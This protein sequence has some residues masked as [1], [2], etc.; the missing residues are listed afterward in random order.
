MAQLVTLHLGK[1]FRNFRG[2]VEDLRDGIL[3]EGGQ[4]VRREEESS[5]RSLWHDSGATLRSLQEEV[6]REGDAIT[7]RLFPTATSDKGAP[8]PLFGEYGTGRR[9][10]IT[11]RP[12]P[13]GY[14]YGQRQGMKARRFS[15]IAVAAAKPQVERA[16]IQRVKQFAANYTVN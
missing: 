15:R 6:V 3:V 1:E 4:I 10:A 16:A 5:I 14:H 11:G 2:Q 13:R 9:G 12:A 7:Y 8:Y